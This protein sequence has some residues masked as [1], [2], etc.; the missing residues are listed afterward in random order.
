V[1]LVGD[2]VVLLLRFESVV[3][4]G[5]GVVVVDVSAGVGIS[6]LLIVRVAFGS[7]CRCCLL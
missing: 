5:A 1:V 2:V 7:C 6:L 3:L 4:V